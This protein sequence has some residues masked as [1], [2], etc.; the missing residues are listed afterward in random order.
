[1]ERSP[2]PLAP[3]ERDLDALRAAWADSLPAFGAIAGTT[4]VELEQMSDSGLV[5]VTDLLA[6]VRRD[7]EAVLARVAAEVARR[8]GPE[9]GDIGLAKA[10]GF[11]NPVRLIAASTGSTR[12]DAAKL[13][14]VGT[15]TAERQTF[16]GERVAS[17]HPH[18]AAA[19]QTAAIGIDAASAI[20][21]ML[22]RVALRADPAH[23][24]VVEAALVELARQVPLELLMRGVREAEA[25]LDA[26]GVEPA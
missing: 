2:Q 19:L 17:K 1:M 8:S 11:H 12:S 7:A 14:G 9:F 26:D 18:V 21:S 20:T 6:R 3:L 10:Q 15:A 5:Q 22:E 24:D 16:G 4:Q 13:I 25:R 23:A